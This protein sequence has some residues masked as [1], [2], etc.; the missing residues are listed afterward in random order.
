MI[1]D[2]RNEASAAVSR[3]MIDAWP[4]CGEP[5]VLV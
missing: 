1:P 2:C 4:L 5:P 3:A